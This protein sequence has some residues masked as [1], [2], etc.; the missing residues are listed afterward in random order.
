MLGWAERVRVR[1]ALRETLIHPFPSE[2]FLERYF[3]CKFFFV[4]GTLNRFDEL[5]P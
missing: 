5:L 4:E 3:G 2:E 1:A